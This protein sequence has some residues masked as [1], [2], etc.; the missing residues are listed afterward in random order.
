VAVKTPMHSPRSSR[1]AA[2]PDSAVI[3]ATA[4]NDRNVL[5]VEPSL[6][7]IGRL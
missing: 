3:I 2:H 7:S 1:I 5:T 4:T 6:P